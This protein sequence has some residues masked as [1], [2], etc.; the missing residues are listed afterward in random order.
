MSE[1]PNKVTKRP[2]MPNAGAASTFQIR[3]D[4]EPPVEPCELCRHI[5]K[6][7]AIAIDGQQL[8]VCADCYRDLYRA[9]CQGPG[10]NPSPKWI[11]K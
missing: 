3:Y 11:K 9:F 4:V 2:P 10:P 7:F 6:L 5:E 8:E 1:N